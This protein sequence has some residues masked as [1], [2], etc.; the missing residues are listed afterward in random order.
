MFVLTY[1]TSS[2]FSFKF[3]EIGMLDSG[4]CCWSFLSCKSFFLLKKLMEKMWQKLTHVS[5]FPVYFTIRSEAHKS[6]NIKNIV[7][8]TIND[9]NH[10]VFALFRS[11]NIE[12]NEKGNVKNE[13][14]S[15]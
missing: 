15:A 1:S 11:I 7:Y 10:Q 3:L 5:I 8:R 2:F 9:M 14:I 4:K 13:L 6:L 12:G